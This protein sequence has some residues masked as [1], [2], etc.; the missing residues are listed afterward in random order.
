MKTDRLI[1]LDEAKDDLLSRTTAGPR[2]FPFQACI[3]FREG[4]LYFFFLAPDDPFRR[5]E[6]G[7]L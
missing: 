1:G 7:S 4:V 5:H 6:F 2:L 3:C